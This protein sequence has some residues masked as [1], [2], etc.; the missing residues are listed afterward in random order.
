MTIEP[1]RWRSE[2]LCGIDDWLHHAPGSGAEV[3]RFSGISGIL[4]LPIG[5]DTVAK[6]S[7]CSPPSLRMWR[8]SSLSGETGQW[9]VRRSELP[10][11]SNLILAVPGIESMKYSGFGTL[12]RSHHARCSSTRFEG[13]V[14]LRFAL[15]SETW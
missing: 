6:P 11:R 15:L 2:K 10:A 13:I 14:T 9:I 7:R 3:G 4:L 12:A 5:H 8:G 1:S